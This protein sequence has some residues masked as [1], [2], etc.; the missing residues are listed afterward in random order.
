MDRNGSG[1]GAASESSI[2]ISFQYDG[3]Q[4]RELIKLKPTPANLKE[5]ERIKIAIEVAIKNGTFDYA[6]VFP[7]SVYARNLRR[8]KPKKNDLLIKTYLEQWWEIE[9]LDLKGSS[10]ATDGG[11]LFNKLIPEFGHL[12]LDE[13][14]WAHIRRWIKGLRTPKDEPLARKTQNNILSV[15]RRALNT[16]IEDEILEHH[17][18]LTRKIRRRKAR[19]A[20]PKTEDEIDPF[21]RKE[22][23]ALIKAAIG[24]RLEHLAKFGFATGMRE[25]EIFALQWKDISWRKRKAHICGALTRH[26]REI[27]STK[28]EA[29]ERFVDLLPPALTSLKAQK[30]LTFDTGTFVFI[31]SNTGG[32]WRDEAVRKA[33]VKLC[34]KAK[35]RYRPPSQMRHTFASMALMAGEPVQWVSEMLGHETWDFT[36]KVYYRWIEGDKGE[37]GKKLME[38][39]DEKE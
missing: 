36:I 18:M 38:K 30:A 31:N 24:T 25:S 27:E 15:L 13:L 4:R 9:K 20:S 29:G 33:W 21:D 8:S 34:E 11:I 22:R 16:A 32:W 12:T 17:P 10:V 28:T 37:A 23:N 1:V 35:V 26:S 2:R 3:E 7:N 5:W 19:K 39:W 6:A 14:K